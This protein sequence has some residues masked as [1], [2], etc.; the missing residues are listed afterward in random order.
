M[1]MGR[2]QALFQ[3]SDL[4]VKPD[5]STGKNGQTRSMHACTPN[6]EAEAA[7]PAAFFEACAGVD[8]KG[9]PLLYAFMMSVFQQM[10]SSRTQLQRKDQKG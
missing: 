6:L 2:L 3:T 7:S 9:E 1:M 8:G 4:L 5:D 10:T